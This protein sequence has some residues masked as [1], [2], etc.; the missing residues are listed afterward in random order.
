MKQVIPSRIVIKN[1]STHYAPKKEQTYPPSN[2]TYDDVF[3]NDE[4]TVCGWR[5][6]SGTKLA[7]IQVE[8]PEI[9]KRVK[10][11]RDMEKVGNFVNKFCNIYQFPSKRWRKVSKELDLTRREKTDPGPL[12]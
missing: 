10:R 3:Y 6:G 2:Y 8:D 11:W 4:G 5:L 9:D 7:R 1:K 12:P